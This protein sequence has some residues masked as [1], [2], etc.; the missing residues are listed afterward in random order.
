MRTIP[1]I[2]LLVVSLVLAPGVVVGAP[3]GTSV[4]ASGGDVTFEVE[5]DSDGDAGST[6]DSESDSNGDSTADSDTD[7]TADSDTDSTA[8]SDTDSTADS[9]TDS[10]ADSD[11]DTTDSAESTSDAGS[12]TDASE[13]DS[14]DTTAGDES[15]SESDTED[16]TDT[17]VTNETETATPTEAPS[18]GFAATRSGV[19]TG[20]ATDGDGRAAGEAV[21]TESDVGQNTTTPAPTTETTA[22]ENASAA[23]GAGDADSGAGSGSS[24]GFGPSSAGAGAAVG[25]GLVA[26]GAIARRVLLTG[27]GGSANTVTSTLATART[28]P[29]GTFRTALSLA[30]ES[31]QRVHATLSDWVG[32]VLGAAGYT[33]WAGDEPLEHDTRAELYDHLQ[34]DPGTYLSAFVEASTL[35]ASLGTI[36][37]HLQILEREGLVTSAKVGGKRRYY[38]IGTSPDALDIALESASTRTIL[39]ELTASSDTVSGLADRID[40]DPSTVSHHLSRLNDDGLVERERD[41]QAVINR[42][43][44]GVET[45]LTQGPFAEAGAAT[46]DQPTTGD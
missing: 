5:E 35:D 27:P 37:Y 46:A 1:V 38:P 11:A 12:D 15:A 44:P 18:A 43:T 10:T 29:R 26:A 31:A 3:D 6:A 34:A 22:P 14:T 9:D 39:E 4:A 20:V 32:R 45:V 36:R 19:P 25:V 13:S 40:R 28:A 33:K 8:D 30:S 7:S 2:S 23:G 16:G 41:G 24:T 17:E 21:L 42:L